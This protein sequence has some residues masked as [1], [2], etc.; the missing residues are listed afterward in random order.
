MP[1]KK[2]T[3]KPISL[4]EEQ[5]EVVGCRNGFFKCMAGPGAGKSQVLVVRFSELIKEGVSADDIISLSFTSAA[6]K[7]LRDRVEAQVGKITTTR[8]AGAVTFHSMALSFAQDERESYPFKL[9]EFPLATEPVSNRIA[10]DVSRRYEI[11]SRALRSFVSLCKRRRISS[12]AS[13]KTA[14]NSL[15]P[16]QLR[17]SLAY[18]GYDAK[19]KENGLLDFDSLIYY[20]VQIMDSQPEVRKRW[21]RDYQQIDEAQDLSKIE[22]DL[23]KLL[24]GKSVL[25]VGDTS[26]GIYSFRG[27]DPRLFQNMDEIFPGTQTLYLGRNYRSSPQI[28]DFIRP[29]ASSQDLAQKFTTDNPSGPVPTIKAFS[30]SADEANWVVSEIRRLNG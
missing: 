3:P 7:N 27:S 5:R 20:M 9:E 24:S 13:I 1:P 28:V 26:Q 14:E 4:N 17:L 12:L 22:W 30:N 25:A 18:K 11:D 10:A 15:D 19:L 21:V 6:A 8:T 23:V 29:L 2:P 16:K